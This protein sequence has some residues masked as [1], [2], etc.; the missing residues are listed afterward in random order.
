MGTDN[1]TSLRP[2][3]TRYVQAVSILEAYI[4]LQRVHGF[5]AGAGERVTA[6]VPPLTHHLVGRP[7]QNDMVPNYARL[8][9][10]GRLPEMSSSS[11]TLAS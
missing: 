8:G 5:A 9:R 6:W 10:G 7:I 1:S 11:S 2:D 3:G 4:E